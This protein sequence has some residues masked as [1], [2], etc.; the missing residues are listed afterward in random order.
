MA[1]LGIANFADARFQTDQERWLRG[2][3]PLLHKLAIARPC[4]TELRPQLPRQVSPACSRAMRQCVGLLLSQRLLR[5]Q[6]LRSALSTTRRSR[7]CRHKPCPAF[8]G[9]AGV[10]GGLPSFPTSGQSLPPSQDKRQFPSTSPRSCPDVI[11]QA[12]QRREVRYMTFYKRR[13]L[14]DLCAS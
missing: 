2:P 11:R 13:C 10:L 1:Y 7:T 5:K 8:R 12:G 3:Q 9:F 4:A 14:K 6:V